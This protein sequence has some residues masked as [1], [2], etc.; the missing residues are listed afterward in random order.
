M[1]LKIYQR[2]I[3]AYGKQGWW[4]VTQ[5]GGTRPVYSGGPKSARQRLEVMVGAVLTQNTAWK[6]VEKAVSVLHRERMIDVSALLSAPQTRLAAMIRSSGYFNQKAAKLKALAAYL[7]EHPTHKLMRRRA[8]A[9]RPE[10]LEIRGVGPETADSILLY[11]LGKPVFVVDAYTRRIFDRLELTQAGMRYE[12]IQEIFHAA[13]PRRT[14]LF[15]EY[16]ALIV[17]H[18]KRVCRKKPLC[19]GCTLRELCPR[20]RAFSLPAPNALRG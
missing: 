12:R 8:P 17:E 10:L 4:P 9:L 3:K 1:F 15:N 7:K 16:H 20:G 11:A 18:G 13:L 19:A 5:P 14:A 6:N 2:L